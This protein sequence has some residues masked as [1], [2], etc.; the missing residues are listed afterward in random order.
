MEKNVHDLSAFGVVPF[1]T[2]EE[3]VGVVSPEKIAARIK[4]YDESRCMLIFGPS[5]GGKSTLAQKIAFA[6]Q[7][8][9]RIL[10]ITSELMSSAMRI[11][12]P[13]I[14]NILN[15]TVLL[16][17]DIQSFANDQN[18]MLPILDQ[19]KD[20]ISTNLIILTYMVQGGT[21]IIGEDREH[22]LQKITVAIG[23]NN[24]KRISLD[25]HGNL[26]EGIILLNIRNN[27]ELNLLFAKLLNIKGIKSVE[28]TV[29]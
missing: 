23:S 10:K 1:K 17:D 14:V 15:P 8:E 21:K 28:R 4:K 22:M 29:E 24:M 2:S 3:Y 18:I 26:F 5:G 20:S 7:P 19:F 13:E 9:G 16:I 12:I 6:S 27:K 11:W 25:S